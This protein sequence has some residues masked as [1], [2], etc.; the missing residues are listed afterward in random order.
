MPTVPK[1]VRE[2]PTDRLVVLAVVL[3]KLVVVADVVVLVSAMK[4]P[5]KVEDAVEINPFNKPKVVEVET[6]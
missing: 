1:I 5:V 2:L 3:N 6:P 4:P